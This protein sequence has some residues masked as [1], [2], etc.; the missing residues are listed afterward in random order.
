MFGNEQFLN[1][2]VN[3]F[4]G[5]LTL[6]A[7]P[8]AAGVLVA[9]A[10]KDPVLDSS[11]Q[12]QILTAR[13]PVVDAVCGY[14]SPAVLAFSCYTWNFQYTL[15]VAQAAKAQFP[16]SLVI[17]G[18]PSIPR[19]QAAITAFLRKSDYVD[20]LVLGEGEAA[21]VDV[22]HAILRSDC[23]KADCLLDVAGLVLRLASADGDHLSIKM[24]AARA[25]LPSYLGT[26]SPYLDGSFDA[27]YADHAPPIN[28]A[29]VETNRGCPFSCTFCDWGQ[30]TQSRVYEMPLERV[31]RELDWI[32]ARQIPSLYFI[33]ANFG[34]RPRDVDII[35]YVTRVKRRTGFP[36]SCYFHLTKNAQLRNL[37]TVTVLQEAGIQ[38]RMAL[39]MQDFNADVLKAIKRDN[40]PAALSIELRKVCN[41]Q[42]IATFNEL[43]LGL[44][45]QTYASFCASVVQAMTPYAGDTFSLYLCRLLENAQ[46]ASPEHR[47]RYGLETVLSPVRS[48]DPQD[49]LFVDEVEE[50]VIGTSAM[51]N[52]Q[53]RNAFRFGYFVSVCYNQGVLR[54]LFHKLQFDSDGDLVQFIE[55]LLY[56]MQQSSAQSTMGKA[57]AVLDHFIDQIVSGRPMLCK[58]EGMGQHRWSIEEALMF[59]LQSDMQGFYADVREELNGFLEASA[60]EGVQVPDELGNINSQAP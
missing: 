29:V 40:I 33:D 12:F 57:F 11:F 26:A 23:L 59:A 50:I 13:L 44:P 39:S 34:I 10:R 18:G 25:R 30:A 37:K 42:G 24:T 28:A 21:F 60:F 14:R 27:I 56:R 5:A 55:K 49:A 19:D 43:L 17:L 8:L 52:R 4:V 36:S 16:E 6:Q 2:Y 53:W 41:K 35:E 3:Q 1:V 48:P 31:F 38:C 46:M 9:S 47:K 54:K 22:L 32:G 51:P 45:R 58:M 20:V 7:L 15:A